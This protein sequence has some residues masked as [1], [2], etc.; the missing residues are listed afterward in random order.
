M[1]TQWIIIWTERFISQQSLDDLCHGSVQYSIVHTS[2]LSVSLASCAFH[3][4]GAN[5]IVIS[6]ECIIITETEEILQRIPTC[7]IEEIGFG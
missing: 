5:H 6:G 7:K 4:S 2:I 1:L 3:Y